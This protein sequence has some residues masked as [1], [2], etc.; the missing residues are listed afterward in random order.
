M[1]SNKKITTSPSRLSSPFVKQDVQATSRG[2]QSLSMGDITDEFIDKQDLELAAQG[3]LAD[4]PMIYTVRRQEYYLRDLT[5][6]SS[7]SLPGNVM[8]TSYRK[9]GNDLGASSRLPNTSISPINCP[10]HGS[11][12]PGF[13]TAALAFTSHGMAPAYMPNQTP[14]ERYLTEGPAE[15]Y[16]IVNLNEPNTT[17][18]ARYNRCTC[19]PNL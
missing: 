14:M 12:C 16:T 2:D 1:T 19:G 18:W 3:S 11:V 13:D 17:D 10:V 9:P 8:Q 15:R 4:F 6:Q 7:N 5:L